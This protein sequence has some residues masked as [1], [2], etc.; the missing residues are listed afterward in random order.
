[1]PHFEIS[2]IPPKQ[3]KPLLTELSRKISTKCWER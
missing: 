1:M 2:T 3:K